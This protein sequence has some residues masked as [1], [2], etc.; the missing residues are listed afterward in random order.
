MG[1]SRWNEKGDEAEEDDP[2]AG[3]TLWL[4]PVNWYDELP[5][6]FDFVTI[7]GAA[8]RVDAG[9]SKDSRMGYLAF[10]LVRFQF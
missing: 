4:M 5:K 6:D 10:G 7:H 3:G 8:C 1:F 2:F 9:A